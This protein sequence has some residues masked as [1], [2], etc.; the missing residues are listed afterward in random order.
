MVGKVPGKVAGGFDVP[1]GEEASDLAGVFG[2]FANKSCGENLQ[3]IGQDG[4]QQGIKAFEVVV[5]RAVEAGGQLQLVVG[6]EEGERKV[7]VD[8]GIHSGERELNAIHA[9]A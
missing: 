3:S 9:G 5:L 7:V 4:F 8:V 2:E 1:Y 6:L